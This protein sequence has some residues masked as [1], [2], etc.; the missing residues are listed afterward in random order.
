FEPTEDLI[1]PIKAFLIIVELLNSIQR[2]CFFEIR[3]VSE[4]SSG[5]E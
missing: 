3:N 4:V 5:N 1:L 2:Q